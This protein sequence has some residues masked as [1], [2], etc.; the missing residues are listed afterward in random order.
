[1]ARIP[2]IETSECEA[3]GTCEAICPEVFKLNE[4]LG[5][6]QVLNPTGAGEDAIQ[7]AIDSCP[8]GCI[9]WVEG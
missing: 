6:A 1:M 3:C 7:E 9:S 5:C 8:P 2:Y 4:E